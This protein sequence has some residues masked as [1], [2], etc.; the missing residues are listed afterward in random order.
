MTDLYP[1]FDVVE[2]KEQLEEEDTGYKE[3]AYFDF[4][5][6]DFVLDETGKIVEAAGSDAWIQW[7][8][9]AVYTQRSALMCYTD[10]YGTEMEQVFAETSKKAQESMLERTI[11]EAL[12]A[13]PYQR[14]VYVRDFIFEWNEDGLS[15]TFT[16]V[17]SENQEE[18]VT[19][20]LQGVK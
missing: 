11:T 6:G 4:E 9:K 16:V 2:I 17:G 10:G 18:Q 1:T 8:L 5:K 14:T 15:V 12:L 7:C 13:D 19:A 20:T 3:S